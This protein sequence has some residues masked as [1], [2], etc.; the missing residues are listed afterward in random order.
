MFK[1][2]ELIY[3]QMH[4]TGCSHVASLLS[5]LFDGQMIG[6]HNAATPEDIRSTPYFISSIRNPWDWYI[7]LWTFGVQGNGALMHQLTK[8]MLPKPSVSLLKN[9]MS[10][11]QTYVR[12]FTKDTETW[13]SV[14]DRSDSVE[15]FRRWLRLIHDHTNSRYLG[16]GYGD[17]PIAKWC[18][19]M[20]YRY[21]YLCCRNAQMLKGAAR[22]SGFD[23]LVQFDRD[24]CYI[25]YF[26]RQE[27][28]EA[29]FCEAIAKVRP[30]TVTE[31]ELVLQLPKTNTSKRMLSS[32]DYYDKES[33][34]L[35]RTR[36]RLL[37]EKFNYSPPNSKHN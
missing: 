31:R 25:N 1:C 10:S 20:T 19:L 14:Y 13:R 27:A 15:S 22:L 32:A 21:L 12:E 4:K 2:D 9:P 23:D 35:I 29:T 37:I 3:I 16:E 26:I 36:D 7:S 24:N 34:E 8:R 30:L 5:K 33:I 6:K 18:G 11:Y 17:T 28:L